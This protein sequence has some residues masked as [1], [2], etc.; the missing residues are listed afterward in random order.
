[1][2]Y[3]RKSA[4]VIADGGTAA[5]SGRRG[6]AGRRRA[7]GGDGFHQDETFIFLQLLKRGVDALRKLDLA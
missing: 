4:I 5:V 1:L 6:P 3:R 2:G 7:G